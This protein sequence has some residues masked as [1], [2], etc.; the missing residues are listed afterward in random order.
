M[1]IIKRVKRVSYGGCYARGLQGSVAIC[2]LL[3]LPRGA[4][5]L[6][7]II[8]GVLGQRK[9]CRALGPLVHIPH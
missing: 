4:V 1:R 6:D 3:G 2:L 5:E 7:Q 8:K 9:L